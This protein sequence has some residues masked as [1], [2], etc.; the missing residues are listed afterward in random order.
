VIIG[1][2][3]TDKHVLIIAEI[4]NNHEGDMV[5]AVRLVKEA[6]TAGVDAV[7]FQTY[8]TELF[9]SRTDPIRYKRLQSF[10]LSFDEFREL[11]A[12]AHS[13]G[14]LFISTPLDL[15]S[16]LFLN[17]I[18]DAFKI[19][20]G[21]ITFYPLL[22]MVAQTGKPIILS[23]GASEQE[24]VDKAIS[25]I[26]KSWDENNQSSDLALLHCVSCY[27]VPPDQVNLGCI[28]TL[29]ER[30]PYATG[31]SDHTIGIEAAILA[32][33]CGA[34]IIEKHFTLDKSF[35]PFRDHQL[36][37]D[38]NDMNELVRKV[39][40]AS[41][42]IGKMP[43]KI[44]PCESEL[45]PT[46]RRSI[47][48]RINMKKGQLIGMPDLIWIRPGGGLAPGNEHVLIGKKLKIKKSAGEQ[49]NIMDIE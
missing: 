25:L 5:T 33:G 15:E 21:D 2:R 22:N 36:S 23:T 14:L 9:I 42:V 41:S 13:L 10:Q 4:G 49:I 26:E 38:P 19:A 30:Y 11:S 39:R 16:A 8:K 31:Y 3:D 44:Q 1:T 7:K 32:V 40:F 34:R 18:V 29:S 37:A 27:P 12:I 35:S 28:R 46:V 45:I 24:Q 47:A 17:D 20:S 6:A 43:K 48:A